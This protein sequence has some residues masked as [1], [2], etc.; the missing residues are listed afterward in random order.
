MKIEIE[1][2]T[3]DERSLRRLT[4]NGRL[5]AQSLTA[6]QVHL[7]I[8][9]I[10]EKALLPD[11]TLRRRQIATILKFNRAPLDHRSPTQASP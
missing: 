5:I 1:G 7:L 9:E 11:E 6:T 8:G 10:F 3:P 2:E 4:L